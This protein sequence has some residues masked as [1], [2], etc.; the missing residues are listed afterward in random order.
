MSE[1]MAFLNGRWIPEAMA[2]VPVADAGFIQGTAIAE[3]LRTFKGKLFKL[4]QHVARLFHSLQILGIDPG[5]KL[6]EVSWVAEELILRN[7]RHISTKADLG[8]TI[9]VTPGMYPT[10][11]PDEPPHPTVCMHTHV[12]PFQLWADTYRTG[13]ALATTGVEQVSGRCW[14]PSLK[15]RSRVHY[16]LADR[17]AAAVAPNAR[18]LLLDAQGFVTEATT[19]NLLVYRADRGLI[20][21]PLS[22]ILHGISLATTIELAEK[23]KIEFSERDLTPKDVASAE[24]AMLTS[25]SPCIL[26]ATELNGHPI[27]DGR[28]GPIFAR[29][30]AA[31]SDLVGLDILKQAQGDEDKT[32]AW[33]QKLGINAEKR[34]RYRLNLP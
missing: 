18:A 10:F 34:L 2:V 14:P 3:Q 19:A 27:G 15:C 16:F 29:L 33:E 32:E 26:P 30:M 1:P 7:F 20:S 22:K 25:T 11:A 23:L 24:E 28:P 31:W 9:F 21:P 4:E 12:L 5:M 8:L 17:Q 6:N 13:Q